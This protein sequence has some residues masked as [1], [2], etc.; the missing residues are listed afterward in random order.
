MSF[1][2]QALSA[3]YLATLK[4]PLAPDVYPVPRHLDQEVG[5]LKLASMGIT[6]DTLTEEQRHYLESWEEGT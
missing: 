6:I 3:E 4:E 1:A 5:R 2:D